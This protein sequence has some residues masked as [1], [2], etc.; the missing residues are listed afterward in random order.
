MFSLSTKSFKVSFE[1]NISAGKSTVF[2]YIKELNVE[3]LSFVDEP[4]DEWLQIKDK[5]GNNALEC[6]YKNQK[7]NSFPFQVLAYI[8]RLKKLIEKINSNPNNIIISERCIETD[9]YVFARMLYEN[10]NISSFEW[11]TYNYWYNSFSELS[12]VDL[13]IYIDTD[14]KICHQRIKKRNRTEELDIPLAYL[15]NCDLKHKEWLS[16]TQTN[17]IKINGNDSIDAIK[18]NVENILLNLKIEKQC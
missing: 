16:G 15:E 7:N 8:T 12:K 13:I 10:G 11:E 9:K 18:L 3:G 1:G 14:P 17:V 6:F 4:V 5:D 2:N